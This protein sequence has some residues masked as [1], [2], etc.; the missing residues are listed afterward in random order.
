MPSENKSKSQSFNDTSTTTACSSSN[1]TYISTGEDLLITTT[2]S[3]PASWASGMTNINYIVN[4]GNIGIGTTTPSA[5]LHISNNNAYRFAE[6]GEI[7]IDP[8]TGESLMFLYDY[9]DWIKCDLE[10]KNSKDENGN[11]QNIISAVFELSVAK[12]KTKQR[13]RI[14]LVEKMKKYERFLITSTGNVGL[15]CPNP[16]NT[17]IINPTYYNTGISNVTI[18]TDPYFS[19]NNTDHRTTA[20]TTIL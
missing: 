20:Y 12:M 2:C 13:E 15:G 14:V 8:K 9:N 10:F 7:R 1:N 5:M 16:Y 17:L 4:S 18:G 19:L 6:D 3:S 11:T